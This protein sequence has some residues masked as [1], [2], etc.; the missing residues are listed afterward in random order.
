L[1]TNG[2]VI[3]PLTFEALV[4]SA[5][6]GQ[7]GPED[8]VWRPEAET[9]ERADSVAELWAPSHSPPRTFPWRRA[10]VAGMAVSGA[11]LAAI[12]GTAVGD[13]PFVAGQYRHAADHARPIKRNCALDDYLAGKCR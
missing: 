10:I 11:L 9:W 6:D 13:F 2:R 12:V 3:G 5:R 1:A 8:C 4:E 7:V